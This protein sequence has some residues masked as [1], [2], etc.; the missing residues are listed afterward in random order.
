M[1]ILLD[2]FIFNYFLRIIKHYIIVINLSLEHIKNFLIELQKKGNL[3]KLVSE[4]GTADE[5]AYIAKKF[6]Y[7]F[8]AIELRNISSDLIAGVKIR[9]QDT[10]PS[11]NFGEGGN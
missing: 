5:I 1:I 4:A 6:G 9:R 10:T 2:N 3:Y 7:E 8:S 11:Y